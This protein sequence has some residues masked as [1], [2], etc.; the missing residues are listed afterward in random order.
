MTD[1]NSPVYKDQKS[2][3]GRLLRLIGGVLDPRAW[4]HLFKIVN[5]YN[6]THVA[7][8]RDIKKGAGC[9]ISPT[10]GF[11]NPQN[12][13][14]GARVRIGADCA[15]WGGPG[16]GKVTLGDDVLLGPRVMM[17]A[18]SYRFNEGS[19]VTN[20]PMK[21]ADITIGRDVWIATGAIILPGTQIGD[22][23]VIGAHAIVRGQ[24]PPYA[25]VASPLAGQV[26]ERTPKTGRI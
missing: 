4:A 5:Y 20:Q 15:I 11:S 7:P 2:R 3:T 16:G 10:A 1:P 6:Y 26:G 22:G 9:A 8:L 12:I 21:E 25:L 14:L 24:V 23:A 18:A 17:T 13:E 19:P